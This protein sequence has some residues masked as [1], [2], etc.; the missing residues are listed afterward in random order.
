MQT[1]FV[2]TMAALA[3]FGGLQGV[4]G[5]SAQ[6]PP[7]TTKVDL[8][9]DPLPPDALARFGCTRLRHGADVW[10]TAFSPDGMTLA[11]GYTDHKVVLWDVQSGKKLRE[12]ECG[13]SYVLAIAFS[14]DGK[15]LATVAS[16]LQ[17]WD[18]QTGRLLRDFGTTNA[19]GRSI[20]FVPGGKWLVGCDVKRLVRVWNIESGEDALALESP[21]IA[22][23]SV[24]CSADGKWII[25]AGFG[26]PTA[27]AKDRPLGFF[28]W[29]AKTGKRVQSW[30]WAAGQRGV[31]TG[32]CNQVTFSPDG[33]LVAATTTGQLTVWETETGKLH[34]DRKGAG[35]GVGFVNGGKM[36]AVGGH[37]SSVL[38]LNVKDGK[39]VRQM[40][41]TEGQVSG[42][43]TSNDGKFVAAGEFYGTTRILESRYRNRSAPV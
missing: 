8:F 33:R 7:A 12:F 14:E 30:E 17:V 36:L 10:S 27:V 34:F 25:G 35:S 19:M 43:A 11:V 5:A 31:P 39:Q 23:S 9:G 4:G 29:D 18:V 15:K 2:T 1:N 32:D 41:I 13:E 21:A 42:F 24:A 37:Y 22:A 6:T 28:V 26:A 40:P 16:K 3:L 38:L 20:A